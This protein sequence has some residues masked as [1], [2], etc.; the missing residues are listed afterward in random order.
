VTPAIAFAQGVTVVT[1][2]DPA[3]RDPD[4]LRLVDLLRMPFVHGAKAAAL[5]SPRVAV[6]GAAERLAE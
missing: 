1:I 6:Q 2:G 4:R 3:R 5:P